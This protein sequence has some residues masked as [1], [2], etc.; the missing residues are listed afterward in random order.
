VQN[1]CTL[2]WWTLK[3]IKFK[4]M[5]CWHETV[6]IEKSLHLYV[7][8]RRA[9]LHRQHPIYLPCDGIRVAPS[10]ILHPPPS[11]SSSSSISS[12]LTPT[13]GGM[14]WRLTSSSLVAMAGSPYLPGTEYPT[15]LQ[16]FLI[17]ATVH[18]F[19]RLIHDDT[20]PFVRCCPF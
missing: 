8:W 6:V 2:P 3:H 19:R 12:W 9:A 13:M 18:F 4:R 7:R 11:S 5:W 20:S 14:G 16:I 15:D 10:S 1:N 17:H